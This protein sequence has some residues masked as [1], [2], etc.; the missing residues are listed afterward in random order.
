MRCVAEGSP[1]WG[2]I[3]LVIRPIDNR[4]TLSRSTATLPSPDRQRSRAIGRPL[5]DHGRRWHKIHPDS[6]ARAPATRSTLATSSCSTPNENKLARPISSAGSASGA[7]G[8]RWS[9]RCYTAVI[10]LLWV[11]RLEPGAVDSQPAVVPMA[12]HAHRLVPA[13]RGD[14]AL[15][16]M[17]SK[18][19]AAPDEP[20]AGP[21]P[22]R[23]VLWFVAH[24][25]MLG[26]H[27]GDIGHEWLR[28]MIRQAMS[29]GR[30]A[31]LSSLAGD[32]LVHLG[33]E[34]ARESDKLTRSMT[35]TGALVWMLFI[36]Q[37]T[38]WAVLAIATCAGRLTSRACCCLHGFTLIYTITLIQVTALVISA[39]RQSTVVLAEMDGKIRKT[40][41]CGRRSDA[42][43]GCRA[44]DC[45]AKMT[46][47]SCRTPA[48]S[49]STDVTT[50]AAAPAIRSWPPAG[51][52]QL[53]PS[54]TVLP[55]RPDRSRPRRCR[56][57][58]ARGATWAE[59]NGRFLPG[60]FLPG[61]SRRSSDPG[62]RR[63][64][65]RRARA[66]SPRP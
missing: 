17:G 64:P 32:Y 28:D 34:N 43:S 4:P 18:K 49:D 30:M 33:V 14:P 57:A 10:D 36:C 42:R 2:Q 26:L 29:W 3:A 31:L 25:E 59:E 62:I 37:Q 40:T 16:P 38:N 12:R 45:V 44:R 65:E 55:R 66:R 19:L 8:Q 47:P 58:A 24:G 61:R 46:A 5:G 54:R 13:G 41:C 27:G 35:V 22:G 60:S 20:A 56:R 11:F 50:G 53:S 1:D 39:A 63:T 51:H 21:V 48:G 52:V 9:W 7:T 6:R 15:G 23:M